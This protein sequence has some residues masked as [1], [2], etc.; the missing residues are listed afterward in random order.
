MDDFSADF[1]P[2]Q[3]EV[4]IAS[5]RSWREA[6]S[7]DPRGNNETLATYQ[8]WFA[9]PSPLATLAKPMYPCPET[10]RLAVAL[11]D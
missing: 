6:E 9:T 3:V 2:A 1:K 4:Q 11:L 5:L 10:S 7:V 8:A